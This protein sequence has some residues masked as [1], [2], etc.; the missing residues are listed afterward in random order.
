MNR[1]LLGIYCKRKMEE[2]CVMLDVYKK[3]LDDETS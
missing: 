3:L 2:I 1:K